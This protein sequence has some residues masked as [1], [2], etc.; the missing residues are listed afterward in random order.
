M[1]WYRGPG[2]SVA[3]LLATQ[4]MGPRTAALLATSG[5]LERHPG[6]HVAL[7]EYTGGWLAWTMTT[8]DHATETFNKYGSTDM[9]GSA[10][11]AGGQAPKPIVSPALREPPSFYIRRQI[12]AT[13]QDEPVGLSNVAITGADCLMWGSDYPHEEG[14]Y[15]HSR[16]TVD[17]LGVLVDEETALQVFRDNAARLFRFA[18]EVLA[19]PA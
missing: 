18:P 4:S 14:T 12:H 11:L 2:A 17:R 10:K 15:P 3:N 7:V 8:V 1:I 16:Q 5:I 19:R 9:L 13:F 6:L